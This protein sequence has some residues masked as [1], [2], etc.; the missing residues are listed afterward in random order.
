MSEIL[1]KKCMNCREKFEVEVYEDGTYSGGHYWGVM[2]GISSNDGEYW[3]C[4]K[5]E[6]GGEEP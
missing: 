4:T 6:C 1:T 5:E 2:D 3:E